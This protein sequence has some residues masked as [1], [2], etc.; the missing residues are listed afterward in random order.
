V[1][2]RSPSR[3]ALSCWRPRRGQLLLALGALSALLYAW[4]AQ[5]VA[6]QSSGVGTDVEIAALLDTI[7]ASTARHERL[8]TEAAELTAQR[9]DTQL[10]LR[11]NVRA[12]YR[13]TRS[14]LSPLV[15]GM[16][17]VLRHV[18]RIKR[19]QSLIAKQSSKL[20]AIDGRT[21]SM[22]A[23]R[24]AA[25]QALAQARARL[26]ALQ[27]GQA[28]ASGIDGLI[29]QSG[30]FRPAGEDSGS[31]YGMRMVDP[32]PSSSFESERGN[33]ASPVTGDVQLV[34]AERAESDGPGLELRA[35]VGTA[36]R[37]VAAGRVA[38]S[39]R[40]GSYGRL[41]ILDHGDGYY[42]VYGG[43]GAVEVRVGDDLSRS[44]R[45]GSIGTDFSPP[46]LFFEV[47]KGTRTLEPRGWLGL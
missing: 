12:L 19:L 14:G 10:G 43:L 2:E 38:F 23:A 39:D 16:N 33:L 9:R 11:N 18:A 35:P 24:A 36:V 7:E 21:R 41:V 3:N 27:S 1:R 22:Q 37:A 44:A 29:A 25:D 15:G 40:Y 46:A 31:F 32:P 8:Q 45:I 6:G 20:T 5:P 34:S 26:A 17:A 30:D 47:R 42:T 13:I 4:R 28:S